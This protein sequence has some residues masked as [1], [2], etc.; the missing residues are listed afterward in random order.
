VQS[1]VSPTSHC[2]AQELTDPCQAAWIVYPIIP[3]LHLISACQ[4][5]CPK[6]KIK[7][8]S[9]RQHCLASTMCTR[10]IC[11]LWRGAAMIHFDNWKTNWAAKSSDP[12]SSSH[13]VTLSW[14]Y[15]SYTAWLPT[16]LVP[17]LHAQSLIVAGSE[18]A[19]TSN[20]MYIMRCSIITVEPVHR[21]LGA[22]LMQP[23]KKAKVIATKNALFNT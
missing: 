18:Q 2:T 17:P 3:T 13:H 14:T 16:Q 8:R 9:T 10:P 12:L 1:K 5:Y 11:A 15:E 23:I 6:R 22:Q 20:G 7:H 19:N 21:L 4:H